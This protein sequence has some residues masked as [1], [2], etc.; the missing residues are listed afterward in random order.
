MCPIKVGGGRHYRTIVAIVPT[1][2]VVYAE[3]SFVRSI[4]YIDL[5][6]ISDRCRSDGAKPTE[7]SISVRRHYQVA[8]GRLDRR[9]RGQY[10]GQKDNGR[11]VGPFPWYRASGWP[12]IVIG[13]LSS[14]FTLV[15]PTRV[16]IRATPT[17][18]SPS[19]SPHIRHHTSFSHH[20]DTDR[21]RDI[22]DVTSKI[23]SPVTSPAAPQKPKIWSV[24]DVMAKSSR[25]EDSERARHSPRSPI[26]LQMNGSHVPHP[27]FPTPHGGVQ[28]ANI[29]RSMGLWSPAVTS[30]SVSRYHP[31]G[32]TQG[33]FSVPH[34]GG[35]T[36]P[37]SGSRPHFPGHGLSTSM[38]H[39][40][41]AA[42]PHA[43]LGLPAGV[44]TSSA[45][46]TDLR[47]TT[48]SLS[49]R[50][51]ASVGSPNEKSDVTKSRDD[52]PIL[53]TAFKPVGR[54]LPYRQL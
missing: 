7:H 14:A 27:A 41:I 45:I 42:P 18:R 39:N 9:S 46:P 37:V 52:S 24:A 5:F 49:A 33:L 10:G 30:L 6:T 53:P 11:L 29:A 25:D 8:R 47:K 4:D 36:G 3:Y 38:V 13:T 48:E 28:N 12:Q 32:V 50:G 16:P 21:P 40:L 20:T 23:T 44:M 54:R 2:E 26:Q 34:P 17:N 19:Q 43:G 31:Y 15:S 1:A 22:H 35:A 51:H